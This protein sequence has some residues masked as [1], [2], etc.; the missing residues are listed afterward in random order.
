ML[1]TA[2]GLV[3]SLSFFLVFTS[4]CWAAHAEKDDSGRSVSVPDHVQRVV[5]LAPSLTD[6]VYALGA[7]SEL[8]GITDFTDYPPQAAREKPSVGG[9]VNP[10]LERI[11]AL[12]PDVVLALPAFNGSETIAALQRLNIPIVQF[13][14][15]NLGDIYRN[16][17]TVGRVLGREHEAAMLA[18]GLRARETAVRNQAAGRT[19]LR[20]LVVVTVGPLIT[21]G[22]SAFITEMISA[23]GGRSVTEEIPQDWLQMDVES[24]L[25]R[26]PDYIVL[27]QGGPVSLKMMQQQAGMRSL[28]AVQKGR[29]I[30]VDSRIQIPSPAAFDGLEDLARQLK[31]VQVR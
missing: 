1:C 30:T 16:V 15:A 10:S 31:S 29:I 9:I 23:A 4:C 24:V 13:S 6:I 11:V 26:K 8:V 19:K 14:T 5:C 20:L 28:E 21:A 3:R 17:A 12:H 22:R 7:Q 25:P 18:A 2:K 27:I